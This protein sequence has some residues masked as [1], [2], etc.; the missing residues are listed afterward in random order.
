MRHSRK[1]KLSSNFKP[2]PYRVSSRKGSMITATNIHDKHTV[3]RDQSYFKAIPEI[4][5]TPK[6][7]IEFEGEGEVVTNFDGNLELDRPDDDRSN[8]RNK[9]YERK[10]YP[11]RNR[12]KV[13]KY[14]A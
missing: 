5:V 7:K 12:R 1:N 11:R 3:T 4:A 10:E 8:Q 9:Q 13:Q 2:Y 14:C 6:P